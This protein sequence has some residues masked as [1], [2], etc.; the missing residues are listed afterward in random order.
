[1]G[2]KNKDFAA[3]QAGNPARRFRDYFAQKL[4][5]KNLAGK[6]HKSLGPNLQDGSFEDSGE[7]RFLSIVKEGLSPDDIYVD[8]GC[9]TL[10]IGLHAIR[11]LNPG[12]YWGMDIADT[13]LE[14]GRGLI[15]EE[16]WAE[17]KPN[18]R[19]ITP[20]AVAE[21]AAKKPQLLVSTRVLKAV[22][23]GDLQEYMGNI[24]QIIGDW[25]RAI[26]HGKWSAADSFQYED[27][28]WAHGINEIRAMLGKE[29]CTVTILRES[30]RPV[31]GGELSQGMF[32]IK[33]EP[34]A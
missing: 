14:T 3:W 19:V 2:K 18:L 32:A 22:H 21:V 30:K 15:G 10:R 8:Y 34:A 20:E 23:Q 31:D 4:Q 6:K 24:A 13:L 25:G 27:W 1:M 12:N 33:R 5:N 11:Y 9:G 28:K 26:V 16:L 7:K 29:G 17:K